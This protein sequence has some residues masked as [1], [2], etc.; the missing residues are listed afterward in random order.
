MLSV[1]SVDV[2]SALVHNLNPDWNKRKKKRYN[3]N[4]NHKLSPLSLMPELWY[5]ILEPWNRPNTWTF[6]H[7]SDA[8][9]PLSWLV[10]QIYIVWVM[11]D[12]RKTESGKRV[13]E[14]MFSFFT[15]EMIKSLNKL[16]VTMVF[17]ISYIC[18]LLVL[19]F[20]KP[21]F[22]T[23]NRIHDKY[24]I[25]MCFTFSDN[26]ADW[27]LAGSRKNYWKKARTTLQCVWECKN[28]TSF[29]W[30]HRSEKKKNPTNRIQM[31]IIIIFHNAHTTHKT[32]KTHLIADPH[33]FNRMLKKNWTQCQIE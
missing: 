25:Y 12:S 22:L 24:N 29:Q 14:H 5:E 23:S 27:H 1:D 30:I 31:R 20:D 7:W 19:S 10:C 6:Q 3:R 17:N 2:V 32:H 13:T 18:I 11:E 28:T 15:I 4:E 8:M 26:N 33:K 16:T 9:C 21:Q